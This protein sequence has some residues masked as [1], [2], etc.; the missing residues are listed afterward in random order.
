ML[1]LL[2]VMFMQVL[3]SASFRQEMCCSA[4]IMF[5]PAFRDSC[6]V[7]NKGLANRHQVHVT[8]VNLL[9]TNML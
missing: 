2:P 1:P 6:D 7:Q 5:K 4:L 8:Q 3:L 9:L